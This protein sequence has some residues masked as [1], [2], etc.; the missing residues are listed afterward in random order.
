MPLDNYFATLE[1]KNKRDIELSDKLK[2]IY[3]SPDL[4]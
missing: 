1:K 3:Q 4:H 2:E